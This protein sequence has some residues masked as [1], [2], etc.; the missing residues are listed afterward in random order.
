[1]IGCPWKG[2]LNDL[3]NHLHNCIFDLDRMPDTVKNYIISVDKKDNTT[4]INS[5]ED[6]DTHNY[7]DFNRNSSL[8]A[9]LFNKNSKLMISSMNIN[10]NS[11][12]SF[13]KDILGDY[14]EDN[15]NEIS[16]SGKNIL[17]KKLFVN[18][19]KDK[20]DTSQI[21]YNNSSKIELLNK[22]NS[23]FD[24]LEK[25]IILSN[26]SIKADLNEKNINREDDTNLGLF[27]IGIN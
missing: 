10:M 19:F 27:S 13:F 26:N 18:N 6:D 17:Y 8:R 2:S 12:T 11:N 15:I 21:N 9:R 1:M 4:N 22:E 20:H 24:K 3:G 14:E 5:F 16:N 23:L 25:N 7:L